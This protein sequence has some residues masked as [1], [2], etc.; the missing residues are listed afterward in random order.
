MGNPKHEIPMINRSIYLLA[1]I[2]SLLS[3]TQKP[4]AAYDLAIINAQVIDLYT[5]QIS[6]GHVYINGKSIDTVTR[7]ILHANR[8]IDAKNH[9]LMPGLW[10][11][12]IHLRGGDSLAGQNRAFMDWFLLHGI[13]SVRDAGGD[14]TDSIQQWSLDISSGVLDGPNIYT[15]GPKID[16]KGATWAGSL[17]VTNSSE[18]EAALDSLEQLHV[19]FVKLYDSRISRDNYLLAIRSAEDRGLLTAGHMPFTVNLE[20]ALEAGLDAVEHLYYVLKG[21]SSLESEIT[22]KVIANELGFWD[23]MDQ[24]MVTYDHYTLDQTITLIKER[25]AMVVPTL[26]IGRTLS[27]LDTDDHSTDP[28]LELLSDPFKATYQGRIQRSLRSSDAARKE[29]KQLD[30]TFRVLAYELHSK[31]VPLMAGSDSGAYNSYVYPGASLHGELQEMVDIGMTPLEALQ[32]SILNGARYFGLQ[33]SIGRI[34]PGYA[35]D[36]ILL[37]ENPLEDI[38]HALRIE[39]VIKGTRV[40]H[41]STLAEKVGCTNCLQPN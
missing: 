10:D 22:E 24:L 9:Y 39:Y 18:V 31:G 16:G 29:R 17:E 11:N 2:F 35:A 32:S 21:A 33:D 30:S 37:K 28:W 41:T 7:E 38:E 20:E 8:Q 5:G 36:M 6:Q 13:T 27:Y 3:C 1:A 4:D 40:H 23:S 34:A 25:G 12:H 26:Y 14:L 15:A 19:D